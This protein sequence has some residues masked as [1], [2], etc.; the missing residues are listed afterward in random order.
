MHPVFGAEFVDP[1]REWLGEW[2]TAVTQHHERWDGKGYPAGLAG[3]EISFPGRIVAVADV[4][5]VI[6]SARS[7]KEASGAVAGREEIARCA[8]TQFDPRV[9]RALLSVSIGRLRFAMGP[10]SWLANAPILGRIPLTP[11]V[12][13]L[14][15][16]AAAVVAA[17][18]S[19][20]VPGGPH[21]P[22]VEPA[23]AAPPVAPARPTPRSAPPATRTSQPAVTQTPK[24]AHHPHVP[25][26]PTPSSVERPPTLEPDLDTTAE[27]TTVDRA[28]TRQ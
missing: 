15:T 26:A 27:D 20:V 28:R 6:T 19:F 10:L 21:V 1:L 5:D 11:G 24:P 17:A 23:S 2:A 25:T 8:G 13:T 18:A 16:S 12:S 14:A 22:R 9:V 7:Y 3:E 4:F